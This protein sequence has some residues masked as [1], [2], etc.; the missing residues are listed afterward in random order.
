MIETYLI[1]RLEWIPRENGGR[2]DI[3]RNC[4]YAPTVIAADDPGG[5]KNGRH[6][7]IA[8]NL[9]DPDEAEDGTW[10]DFRFF[11][12]ELTRELSEPGTRLAV[13]EGPRQV[14]WLTVLLAEP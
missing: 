3:P 6:W 5:I 1:G 9:L 12:P 4:Q 7:S 14:A 10:V 2:K 8:I 11:A 13:M